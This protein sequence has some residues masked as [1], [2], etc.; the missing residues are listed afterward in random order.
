M[1]CLGGT[2]KGIYGNLSPGLIRSLSLNLRGGR[3][4]GGSYWGVLYWS[5][6]GY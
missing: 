3:F 6:G 4:Y 1:G 5:L 2:S